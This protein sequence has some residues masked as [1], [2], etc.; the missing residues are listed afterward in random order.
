[1]IGV[2]ACHGGG[3]WVSVMPKLL[4][5]KEN[6]CQNT[7][8][9]GRGGEH[10]HLAEDEEV[11]SKKCIK[12]PIE[13]CDEMWSKSWGHFNIFVTSTFQKLHSISVLDAS[14]LSLPLFILTLHQ[15]SPLSLLPLAQFL[16]PSFTHIHQWPV[17]YLILILQTVF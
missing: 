11:A 8:Q 10:K 1:M 17:I 14:F 3:S 6:T 7:L 13:L 9:I 16:H 5:E 12:W 4:Y 15:A 2:V